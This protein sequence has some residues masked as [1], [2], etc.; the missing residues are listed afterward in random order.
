MVTSPERVGVD[1]CRAGWVVAS[2]IGVVVVPRLQLDRTM[3]TGIDMPIGLAA[4]G[5][6]ACDFKAREFLGARRS[7][8]FPAPPR[9]CIDDTTHAEANATARRVSGKGLSI[10]TFHLFVKI[11][12]L[13]DLV[14]P[15]DDD[16][17]IEVHPEC[18]FAT[19]CDDRPLPSKHTAEGIGLRTALIEAEFG[20]LPPTPKGAQLDDVLD[21]FA[22]LWSVERFARGAHRTFGDGARDERDLPMRIVC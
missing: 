16:N 12:E 19:M 3:I 15:T 6:R 18:A 11:R 9:A 2:R 7:T 10:Q 22:V 20:V 21:A 4:N 14:A 5:R 8:V 1:G 17:V 13:D